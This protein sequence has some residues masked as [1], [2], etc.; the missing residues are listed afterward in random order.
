MLKM[1]YQIQNGGL[2]YSLIFI[3]WNFAWLIII[4][5]QILITLCS[6]TFIVFFYYKGNN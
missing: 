3:I 1:A 4:E 6:Y 2:L 5:N